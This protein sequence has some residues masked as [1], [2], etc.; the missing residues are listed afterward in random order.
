MSASKQF[1]TGVLVNHTVSACDLTFK[2]SGGTPLKPTFTLL[3]VS[4][5]AAKVI[6]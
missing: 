3:Q 5:L 4:F 1:D 6:V 2:T